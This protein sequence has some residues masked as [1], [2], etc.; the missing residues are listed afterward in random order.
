LRTTNQWGQDVTTTKPGAA[1]ALDETLMSY[2]AIG[3][4]TGDLLKSVLN[5]DPDM[6]MG[7]CLKGYFFCLMAS[8]SLWTRLP[9]V[10]AAA[11]QGL[12]AA[13]P[14]EQAHVQALTHWADGD[15]GAAARVWEEILSS[16]PLDVLA[17]RLAHHAYFYRGAAGDML[18]SIERV[19][20]AWD[21]HCPGYGFVLGMRSFA[22]EET[23]EYSEAEKIGRAAVDLNADDPWAIHAVAHVMEMQ[24]R[25]IE[26]IDWITGLQ[27]HWNAANNFRYHL[28]WHRALMH[29]DREELDET[30]RLY[31]ENI[32]D[33]E[34]DEY[35]DLCNDVSL[36]LRLELLGVD[37]GERWQGITEKVAGRTGER[38]L[39]FADCHFVAA[40]AAGGQ[41][42]AAY[43]MAGAMAAAGGIFASVGAPVSNALI[44]HRK[45]DYASAAR[46]LGEVRGT[47][48]TMGG[49]HAQRELF[50]LILKDAEG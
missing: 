24:D 28:W 39:A 1:A 3:R 43:D 48:I 10:L 18:A 8:G 45:A 4:E 21:E 29:L 22:L 9:K 32:W 14:R 15:Q 35:L 19:L 13:T 27:P 33:A 44:A 6:V 23:G 2:L 37:V 36:L 49:S 11:N 30:L 46:L 12:A 34:S 7:H 40:L 38:I 50:E 17:L 31:D 25:H 47:I 5:T 41:M 20:G 16:H 26:G 42:Q